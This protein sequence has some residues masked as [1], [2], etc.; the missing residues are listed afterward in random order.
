M[1]NG[2][3]SRQNPT[4]ARNPASRIWFIVFQSCE[5]RSGMRRSSVRFVSF[6]CYPSLIRN[7]IDFPRLAAIIRKRLFKV[8]RIRGHV[9]PIESNK[10]CFAVNR[11]LS[12][13]LTLSI[14]EFADLGWVKDANLAVGPI[15][16]PLVGLRIVQTE[17]QTLDVARGAIGLER[18]Q[19]RAAIPH[20]IADARSVEFDP[21]SRA[22]ERTQAALQVIFP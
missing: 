2:W 14:L 7:P 3:P 21:G 6:I 10:D 20:L 18:I 9:G 19:L 5:P 1:T 4:R 17:G 22:R 11:I 12:K 16:A 13:K 8:R 15:E